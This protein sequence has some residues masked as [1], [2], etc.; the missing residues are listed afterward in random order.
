MHIFWLYSK[1][2]HLERGELPSIQSVCILQKS[3][4]SNHQKKKKEKKEE[5]PVIQYFKK[6]SAYFFFWKCAHPQQKAR[7]AFMIC[8]S[9][10]V[11]S[12]ALQR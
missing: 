10:C 9:L 2:W 1:P 6:I 8:Y 5:M 3:R 7:I 12:S 4:V 11:L